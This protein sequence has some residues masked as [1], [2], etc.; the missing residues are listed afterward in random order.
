VKELIFQQKQLTCEKEDA[1]FCI[2]VNFQDKNV[3]EFIE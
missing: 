1:L 3:N 2:L